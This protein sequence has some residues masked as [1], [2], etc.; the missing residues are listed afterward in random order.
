MNVLRIIKR[1]LVVAA[2]AACLSVVG[3][4]DVGPGAISFTRYP[5]YHD[6]GYF[7][8]F[9]YDDYYYDPYYYDYVVVDDYWY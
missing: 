5:D 6:D 8:D 3:T 9:W 7:F 2:G 4:C 1:G